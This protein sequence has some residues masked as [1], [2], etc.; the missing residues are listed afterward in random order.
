MEVES[1]ALSL[2]GYTELEIQTSFKIAFLLREPQIFDTL[3]WSTY[4][5]A[6]VIVVAIPLKTITYINKNE[7]YSI[8]RKFF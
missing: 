5:S 8:R 7:V 4:L 6:L 2:D 1:L 3:F